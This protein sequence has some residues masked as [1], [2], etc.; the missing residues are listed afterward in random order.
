[1]SLEDALKRY[2]SHRATH[3]PVVNGGLGTLTRAVVGKEST[4]PTQGD[5]AAQYSSQYNDTPVAGNAVQAPSHY[6]KHPS[7]VECK[8]II[9][10]YPMFVGSAMKYLWRAGLKNSAYTIQDFEKAKECIQI[11]IDMLKEQQND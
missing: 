8:D 11:H 6:T 4:K 2:V 9:K 10:H 3:R 1:M 5:V 7:G